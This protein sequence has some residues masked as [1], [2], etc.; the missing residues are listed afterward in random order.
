MAHPKKSTV[1]ENP[2]SSGADTN[3]AVQAASPSDL[4]ETPAPASETADLFD[5]SHLRLSQDFAQSL[6]V[7][8]NLLMV[9]VRKPAREWWVR[10]HPDKSYSLKVGVIELKEDRETYLVDP[11]L[12][13]QLAAEG[14]FGARHIVTAIN[15]QK[16]VFLWLLRLTGP[17][18]RTNPWNESALE[19]AEM[20][21]REWV[22]VASNMNLGAYEV[23]TSKVD[24]PDP[25]WP[26]QKL[27]KLLEIAF[28]D[29]FIQSLDHAVLKR[30]RGEE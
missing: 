18:G 9:P 17:D 15:R 1:N 8:K 21:Q 29:H 26:E 14:T 19:A 11:C 13:D 16:V 25:E 28:K 20:A 27:G 10:V 22:R 3:D 30:L 5:P 24:L 6:G 12:H 7:K 4:L 23:F 2:S